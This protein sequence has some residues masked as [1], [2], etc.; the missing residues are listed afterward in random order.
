MA[1][2]SEQYQTPGA[3]PGPAQGAGSRE[4]LPRD[5]NRTELL[6][7]AG[8][9]YWITPLTAMLVERF[10][11]LLNRLVETWRTYCWLVWPNRLMRKVP[12]F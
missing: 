7:P 10:C 11:Q 3:G 12:L 2:A 4:K 1:A 8:S 5:E 9:V 6:V